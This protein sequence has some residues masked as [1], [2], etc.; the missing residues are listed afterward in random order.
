MPPPTVPTISAERQKELDNL[1]LYMTEADWLNLM[2]QVGSDPALARELLGADVNEENFISRMNE[3]KD[4]KKRALAEL[5]YRERKNKPLK[6][7]ELTTFMRVFV[8][9]QWSAV[10]NGTITMAQVKAM[11]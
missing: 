3:V 8:K 9:G 10:Y 7:S 6:K 1:M 2:L 4:R 5:R 11:N